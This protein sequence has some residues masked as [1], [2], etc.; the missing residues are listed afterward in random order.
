MLAGVFVEEGVFEVQER[1]VPQIQQPDDVLIKVEGCG[2]C[3]TDLHILSTPAGHPATPGAIL[4]HEFLGHIVEVGSNVNAFQVGQRVVVDPNL[5]CGVCAACRQGMENQ[6]ENWTTL[7]IFLDGGFSNYV[8]APQRALHPISEQVAFEDAVWTEILSCVVASSDRIAIQPGQT[9]A[10]IGAGPVGVLYGLLF[11]AAGAKVII[12]DVAPP[13]LKLAKDVGVDVIVD[14]QSESLH[15]AVES[16]THNRGVDVVVD[17]VGTQIQT[18]LDVAGNRGIVALFGMNSNAQPPVSQYH[19]TRKE[20]TVFGSYVGDHAFP[21]AIQMLESGAIQPSALVSHNLTVDKML[22]GI[23][24]A[25]R[26]EAMKV[27]VTPSPEG[28]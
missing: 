16:H 11:K 10:I 5:K 27:V 22:E 23:E 21:R 15:E 20:L 19:I 9:A 7:G 14:V 1:P 6:C 3:G 24:A 2:L 25:Q 12:S 8:T 4:G 13:R 18:C 17:A 26:G 28:N